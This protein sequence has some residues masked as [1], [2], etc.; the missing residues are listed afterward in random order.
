[1]P[2][3]VV[4]VLGTPGSNTVKIGRT[5]NL[6]KRVGDIQRMSPVRLTVLWTTPGGS[7]LEAQLHRHFA[8]FRSH[9]E[10]FTFTASDP[11]Q[12]IKSAV[13]T[14]PWV[15]VTCA[16]RERPT[17]PANIPRVSKAQFAK[18]LEAA[19]QN[20]AKFDTTELREAI[21]ARLAE[22]ESIPDAADRFHE[23]R[24]FRE[25][26]AKAQAVFIAHQRGAV[27][28]LKQMGLSWRQIGELFGITG[29]RA[30][31]IA[32]AA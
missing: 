3:G 31:Q 17:I 24:A 28:E 19:R 9:G 26:L 32:K 29:A 13:E 27:V 14:A 21:T 12:E 8:K 30:E 2:E 1:M 10:W 18:M 23:V 15:K 5:T 22:L 25:Q 20:S 4:Y 11:V 6:Q 7:E 16:A